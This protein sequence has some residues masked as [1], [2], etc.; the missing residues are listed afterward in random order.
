MNTAKT[1]AAV[2]LQLEGKPPEML[3]RVL[4][5]DADF[6]QT[7]RHGYSRGDSRC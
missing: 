5:F 1:I 2:E 3:E 6:F 4:R 7:T